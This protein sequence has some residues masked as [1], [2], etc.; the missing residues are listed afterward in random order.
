[1]V[2]SWDLV[3]CGSG[4]KGNQG[5]LG[6]CL[7]VECRGLGPCLGVKSRGLGPCLGVKSRGLG[8]VLG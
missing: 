8:R 6:P 2:W 7:G 1:M 3:V 5:I 4:L